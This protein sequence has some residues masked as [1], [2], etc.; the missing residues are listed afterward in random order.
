MVAMAEEGVEYAI[1][2]EHVSKAFRVHSDQRSTAKEIFVR[3]FSKKTSE[4]KALDDVSF[5]IRKGT[6]FGLTQIGR[7]SC[8]E[9]V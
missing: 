8:R 9:R 1:E 2:V 4:F 5:K 7:A 3:G 6:T